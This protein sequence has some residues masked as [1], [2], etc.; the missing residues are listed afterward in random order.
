LFRLSPE[1]R[2]FFY[3]CAL[4]H[5]ALKVFLGLTL[6]TSDGYGFRS[7]VAPPQ[8]LVFAGADVVVSFVL[9][10]LVD[11]A[12]P[13]RYA[14]GTQGALLA[15]ITAFLASSFVIHSYF[16]TFLNRGLLEFNGA[17]TPELF[18]YTLAALNVYAVGFLA[19][20]TALFIYYYTRFSTFA[21]T[22]WPSRAVTPILLLVAS[23]V[24]M[25]FV[26]TLSQGQAGFL[27]YNPEY[28]L[29]QSYMKTGRGTPTATPAEA[30]A[31]H[32]PDAPLFGSYDSQLAV[33]LPSQAKRNV[34]FVLIESL[35]LEQTVLGSSTGGLP[36]LK[37]LAQNGLVFDNFRTVFP[38]T[39]RSFMTY[40]CGIYPSP[41]AATATKYRPGY[42]CDSILDGLKA[43]GYRTGFFTAP[44]FT[45]DNL[46]KAQFMRS[47]DTYADFLSLHASAKKNAIDAPAVE[48][49]VVEHALLDFVD[50]GSA[51]PFFA[52]YFMFWNHAPYRLPFEDLSHLP[53][54]ARYQRTLSYL[55]G[56]LRDLLA[57]LK[58]RGVLDNTLVV[59]AADHGEGFA[60]HHDNTNHIGHVFEDDVRIPFL[61]HVPDPSVG[62]HVTHRQGSNL[63]FA[64][65][66]FHLLGI[67][68][69][70]SWQGQD[71]LAPTF[72]ARPTLL[73]G[74]A[75][76][77]TN[78]LVDGQ[79]KYIEYPESGKRMLFDLASDPHEQHDLSR[80]R[81]SEILAYQALIASW[82]P[83][84][85]YR[86]WAE[87]QASAWRR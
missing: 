33:T 9:A 66:L 13:H 4:A 11:V 45:Y 59:V 27:A 30:R 86:S 52:T 2:G 81:L 46:H 76:Y 77:F 72:S 85:E 26:G 55:D 48:E 32:D 20:T 10:K 35:P 21:R 68:A 39:S 43:H 36:V 78:A 65:T 7:L 70:P 8:S 54:L 80:S 1:A 44:M 15:L 62:A 63:D 40:H 42:R 50:K 24:S 19:P 23:A 84:V 47:Y 6:V 75:S 61:I 34:L 18:D 17:S 74:R 60:L 53:P 58:A 29:A 49:E 28:Q 38:A 69:A 22:G 16:K 87:P 82:L 57:Q 64:P 14:R 56:V 31:F 51:Q 41:G 83:V 12:I 73:F 37:E 71:L 3:V 67:P 5:A 79:L 25:A